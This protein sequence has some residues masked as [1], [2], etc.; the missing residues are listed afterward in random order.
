MLGVSNCPI[1]TVRH[2]TSHISRSAHESRWLG[3]CTVTLQSHP[4]MAHS[5]ARVETQFYHARVVLREGG[6]W[7]K[8][9][10]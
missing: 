9:G 2:N 5:K 4:A 6:S 8:S 3:S 7:H 1:R 10:P